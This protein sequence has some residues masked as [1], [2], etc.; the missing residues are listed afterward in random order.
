MTGQGKDV[1]LFL[2]KTKGHQYVFDN[3]A[4]LA[5]DIVTYLGDIEMLPESTLKISKQQ[6]E[7]TAVKLQDLADWIR[8]F[9][10]GSGY[11]EQGVKMSQTFVYTKK[12]IGGEIR[13]HHNG[14]MSGDVNICSYTAD[15]SIIFENSLVPGV[16]L[17]EF[18]AEFV[19]IS[20]ISAIENMPAS[21][22]LGIDWAPVDAGTGER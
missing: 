5:R 4:E 2:I 14:D 22:V 18:I 13:I 9:G 15:G 1:L 16:A 17:V 10:P 8:E 19:R 6:W 11:E 12:G 3:L 20:R 21:S 7:R